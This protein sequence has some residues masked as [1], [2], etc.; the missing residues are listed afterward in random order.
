MRQIRTNLQGIDILPSIGS[1]D[2]MDHFIRPC[3]SKVSRAHYKELFDILFPKHRLPKNFKYNQAK[4]TFLKGGYYR[5]DFGIEKISLISINSFYFL[6]KNKCLHA[7]A[8]E[9]IKWFRK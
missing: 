6:D 2:I 1:S 4:E 7:Q 3:N 8:E 5:Y 9:Q